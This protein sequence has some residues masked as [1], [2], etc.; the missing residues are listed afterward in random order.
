MTNEEIH[1]AAPIIELTCSAIC[2][3]CGFP[4]G[5]AEA[6]GLTYNIDKCAFGQC[7]IN[8][9]GYRVANGTIKPDPERLLPLKNLPVPSDPKSLKRA[10]GLFSYYSCW[11]P[12]FSKKITRLINVTNFPIN[13]ECAR[14]FEGLKHDVM[15][16]CLSYIDESKHL[17]VGTDASYTTIA[18]SLNKE[19][20]PVAFFAYSHTHRK[21]I[22]CC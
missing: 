5:W 4:I 22:L 11:F 13:N 10:L 2:P 18:A 7:E 19:G 12:N 8:T 3:Y 16:A 17:V 15:D 1:D 6:H 21:E 9:L 14:D 20:K